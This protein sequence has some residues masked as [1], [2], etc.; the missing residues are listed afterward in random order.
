MNISGVY[1]LHFLSRVFGGERAYDL[2][3]ERGRFLSRV[4]GGEQ[5][6]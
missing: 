5:D 6:D 4:F 3:C 2:R 1:A